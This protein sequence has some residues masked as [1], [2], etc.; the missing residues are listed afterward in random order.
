MNKA[1]FLD[2]DGVVVKN[3]GSVAPTNVKDL[4]LIPEAITLIKE[5][6]KRGYKIIVISNQP[7][8]ALGIIDELTKNALVERFGQLI[9]EN[10]VSLDG[11]YY[12]FHHPQS[13]IKKYAKD[14]D[15]KKPKPGLLLKAYLDHKIDPAKSFIIGDR[16]SDIKAGSLAGVR[17]ILLDPEYSEKNY[18]EEYQVKPDF[19]V[20]KLLEV[21]EIIKE[22]S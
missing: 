9:E 8:V 4:E 16:A 15:C 19:T 12:C 17:T 14:C 5:L 3:I 22:N 18:L 1:F 13:A 2:R 20:N 11:I 10:D 6:Q 7:D 21:T